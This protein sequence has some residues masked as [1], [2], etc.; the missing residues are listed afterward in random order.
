MQSLVFVDEK[1]IVN[2]PRYIFLSKNVTSHVN[3][4]FRQVRPDD[5]FGV[6]SLS[7]FVSSFLTPKKYNVAC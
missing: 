7:H 6:E 2:M 5:N 4:H 1:M 3:D